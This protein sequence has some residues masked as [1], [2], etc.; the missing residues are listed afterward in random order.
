MR[1]DAASQESSTS[2]GIT[3]MAT[4]EQR[5]STKRDDLDRWLGVEYQGRSGGRRSVHAVK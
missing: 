5:K 3:T 1:R 4:K 2:E